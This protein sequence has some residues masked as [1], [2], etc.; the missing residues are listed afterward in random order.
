[1]N[2]TSLANSIVSSTEFSQ[3][4]GTLTN[5]EFVEQIHQN[6]LGRNATT[7]ELQNWLSQLAARTVTKASLAA[8]V[9][10]SAEHIADGNVTK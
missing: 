8:A 4:Y 3:K 9:S 5:T 6:A 7:S 10:E 2:Y 1:M